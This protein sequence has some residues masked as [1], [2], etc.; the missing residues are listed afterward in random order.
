MVSPYIRKALKFGFGVL[1]LMRRYFSIVLIFIMYFASSVLWSYVGILKLESFHAFVYDL[2]VQVSSLNSNASTH[3]F[4]NLLILV[5]AS[6]PFALIIS[7]FTL[8]FPGPDFFLILQSFGTLLASVFI[9]L[10]ADRKWNS[11]IISF[12]L[13]FSF[14][15]FFPISWYLFF[16]FHIAGFFSTFFFAGLYFMDKHPRTSVILFFL[17]A[18]TNIVLAFFVL[19]FVIIEEIQRGF[20]SGEITNSKSRRTS[21]LKLALIVS[22]LPTI[23]FATWQ[24]KLPGLTSF[25]GEVSATSSGLI[26]GYLHNLTSLLNSGFIVL[27]IMG[28]LFIV[29]L[30]M[31]VSKKEMFYLIAI[32]P[33]LAFILFGGYPFAN[34]KVQYNGEYFTPLIYFLILIPDRLKSK[35]VAPSH[36]NS[37]RMPNNI[38]AKRGILVFVILILFMGI[39]YNPYGPLNNPNLPGEN[40]YADFYHQINVTQS[41]IIANK[42][43]KLVPSNAT[44]LVED[45]EPQYSDRDRNFLFGPGNLPWLSTSFY[46]TGPKPLSVIPEYIAVDVSGWVLNQGWYNFPFYNSSDGSMLTWFPYFFSHYDYKLLAYS[47][48][49]Y[50]YKLNYSGLPVIS[51]GLNFIG[52][53]YVYHESTATL[54]NFNGN[55]SN[56]TLLNT[57]Y[58]DFLLPANYMYSFSIE[59]HN[60]SGNIS[61]AATN[62]VSSFAKSCVI[63][64]FS[65]YANFSLNFT[66]TEQSDYTF[67][68]V[69]SQLKGSI[70]EYRS[71]SLNISNI[72]FSE[73]DS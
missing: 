52:S 36:V 58:K 60:L 65:G 13:S 64:N 7:Y 14:I 17:A 4:Y 72:P 33:V 2:G 3:S 5:P 16:D 43:V 67:S 27:F 38:I 19:V 24:Y 49:F 46:D 20:R 1:K 11:R 26:Q 8:I 41:D 54:Y 59:A 32:L 22:P 63:S 10:I 48:P 45:N 53:E 30:A 37:K 35:L 12:L 9:F 40:A 70:E 18:T 56:W 39:F 57:L 21:F 61:L 71:E 69:T 73:K 66:V 62:G 34:I 23:L 44:V 51:S 50:L 55:L 6:K 29:I 68:V 25:G 28:I 47:Y 31:I 42:F 15:F